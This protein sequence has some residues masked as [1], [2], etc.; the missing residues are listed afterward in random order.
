MYFVALL[1]A[2]YS[3]NVL[4]IS[5]DCPYFK[6]NCTVLCAT[7]QFNHVIAIQRSFRCFREAN[8][9]SIFVVVVYSNE[10]FF[11]IGFEIVT[12]HAD[13]FALPRHD[14]VS[15]KNEE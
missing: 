3:Q 11:A 12:S 1:V 4:R 7:K 6:N 13:I 8:K 9:E 10:D 5:Y 2:L 15:E 14:K